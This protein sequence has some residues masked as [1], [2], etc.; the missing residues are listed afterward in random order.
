MSRLTLLPTEL[1]LTIAESLP[2]QKDISA[3]TQ[4]TKRTYS[5]LQLYLYKNNIQNHG[6]SALLWAAKN[7]HTVLT[8]K[9][10]D[11]GARISAP[12]N[13]LS[14][15]A[16]GPHI[17]T[18]TCLLS[19][20]RPDQTYDPDQLREALI[21]SA[22]PARS[23]EAVKLLLRHNAPLEPA[24]ELL[25]NPSALGAAVAANWAG[26]I[27]LLLEAGA[28]PGKSEVPTPLERAITMN[29]P[30]IVD[31]LL[32]AGIRLVDDGGL[33]IIAEQNNQRLLEVFVELGLEVGMCWQGA[34][35]AA[36]MHGQTEMVTG[37]IEKG[38]NPNLTYDVF[39]LSF[40]CLRYSTIGFA[41]QFGQ[42]EVLKLLLEK[43][44]RAERG[45]L[46][47]ARAESFEEAVALLSECDFENV[48]RKEN[49][50]DFV[51]KKARE[52]RRREPGYE[53]IKMQDSLCDPA[54][55]LELEDMRDYS[56]PWENDGTQG[57]TMYSS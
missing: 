36:V 14:L 6:T 2:G 9:M 15:A 4:T 1:L 48:P 18:L 32:G 39:M 17:E 57:Y 55:R 35:F 34:L 54:M 5:V 8:Q 24:G 51:E 37:L 50:R 19:E 52:R 12:G 7:G 27:P 33:C 16:S 26:I 22:I 40:E 30:E 38:A 21:E 28:C 13:A 41:V 44:V 11:A 46:N 56:Y 53:G 47:L 3:F 10:L 43:G 42:L 25:P 20:R 29:K 23:T 31:I 49:V 45:D